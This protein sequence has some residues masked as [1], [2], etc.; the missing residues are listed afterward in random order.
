MGWF[1]IIDYCLIAFMY[2]PFVAGKQSRKGGT[3]LLEAR[4]DIMQGDHLYE[5]IPL[6]GAFLMHSLFMP[7]CK[8]REKNS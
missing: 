7:S 5:M 1:M 6:Y 3:L 4:P 8:P 2:D